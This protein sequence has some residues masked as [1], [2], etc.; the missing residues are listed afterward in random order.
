[1]KVH[2]PIKTKKLNE[3]DTSSKYGNYLIGS[4][5]T[6]HGGIHVEK[7]DEEIK[8]IADGRIIAYRF[9]DTYKEVSRTENSIDASN[10]EVAEKN[11]YSNC[12]VLIQHDLELKKTVEEGEGEKKTTKEEKKYVTFYSLYN[13][14][15]PVAEMNNKS[16]VPDMMATTKLKVT[17]NEGFI[18]P[19]KTIKGLNARKL[20][21]ENN[22]VKGSTGVK[23]VIPYGELVTKQFDSSNKLIEL[24][25]YTK[26]E[27]NGKYGYIYAKGNRIV[28][29]GTQ[30]KIATQE[31]DK[32]IE[33]KSGVPDDKKDL[34]GARVR[35][36]GQGSEI[37]DIIPKDEEVIVEEKKGN[38]YKIK[39]YEGYSHKSNFSEK[40]LVDESKITKDAI[41]A[42]DIPIKAGDGIGYTGLVQLSNGKNTEDYYATHVEVFMGDETEDFLNNTFDAG[43]D[44][45]DYILLKEGTKLKKEITQKV[46]LK[47]NLPIKIV[48]I[49]RIYVKIKEN[50]EEAEGIVKLSEVT[51]QGKITD[52]KTNTA[53]DYYT[54]N[55]AS[56]NAVNTKFKN[57]LPKE[58]TVHLF[59]VNRVDSNGNTVSKNDEKKLQDSEK[60]RK[61]RYTPV[62]SAN[63]YWVEAKD[64]MPTVEYV[65]VER[66]KRVP[67]KLSTWERIKDYVVDVEK[68]ETKKVKVCEPKKLPLKRGEKTVTSNAITKVYLAIPE[69]KNDVDEELCKDVVVNISKSEKITVTKDTEYIKVECT[70]P[71]AKEKHTQQGWVLT[72]DLNIEKN[73]FSAYNWDKFSFKP[74]KG[75]NEY[76]YDIQGLREAEKTNSA[77]IKEVWKSLDLNSDGKIELGEVQKAYSIL[78]T[79]NQLT[80]LVCQHKNEWSYTGDELA[81]EIEKYFDYFINHKDTEEHTKK[82]Y[83][84]L[85]KKK[86]DVL[87]E[88]AKELMFWKEASK[89]DVAVT[90]E[91]RMEKDNSGAL[92]PKGIESLDESIEASETQNT[93]QKSGTVS[94]EERAKDENGFINLMKLGIELKKEEERKEEPKKEEK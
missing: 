60:Y 31:D 48:D 24:D 47:K 61:L 84:A 11:Q 26:I 73:A 30:F 14:L 83:K 70:Y 58:E 3:L 2:Y 27:Y 21:S 66:E 52:P 5:N 68:Y 57:K 63:E 79:R 81:G 50:R 67:K 42:C 23:F 87:K 53:R 74:V 75:G 37:V 46:N 16:L 35:K 77:F 85:K 44:K 39:G 55:K 15:L 62:N 4:N 38:W 34:T 78:E 32:I 10:E 17:E 40:K 22:V 19:K 8:A 59:W 28:D 1:M 80:K 51:Y 12:F 25:G 29:L 89:R 18:Y 88:Q 71:M 36:T 9:M 7:K 92:K 33:D 64:I 94:I 76:M 45:K 82:D 65:E 69:K 86:L 43:N 54:I 20:S 49:K 93:E 56:F 72:S 91:E 13:H 90:L 41:I 6:W